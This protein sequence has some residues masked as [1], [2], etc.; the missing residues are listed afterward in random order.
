M[1]FFENIGPKIKK[2][3]AD[4]KKLKNALAISKI[5]CLPSKSTKISKNIRFLTFVSKVF[6]KKSF[7]A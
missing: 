3:Y 1:N 4:L 5:T 6:E 2:D 7:L